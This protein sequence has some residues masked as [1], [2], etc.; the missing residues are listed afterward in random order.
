M[1]RTSSARAHAAIAAAIDVL[2]KDPGWAEAEA[3]YAG[4]AW[5]RHCLAAGDGAG[6]VAAL[7]V[8]DGVRPADNLTRWTTHLPAITTQLG[9]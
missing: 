3:I 4:E 8:L 5:P 6:A 9:P 1:T 2:G 7:I